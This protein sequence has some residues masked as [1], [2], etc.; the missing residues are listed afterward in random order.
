MAL[1]DVQY[2][3]RAQSPGKDPVAKLYAIESH[4]TVDD[5]TL[6]SS[7]FVANGVFKQYKYIAPNIASDSQFSFE[8]QDQDDAVIFSSGNI[9]D[10]KST[11]VVVKITDDNARLLCSGKN[12]HYKTVITWDTSGEVLLNTFKILLSLV[13]H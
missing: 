8:I 3:D 9:A 6:T 7:N 1:S 2:D 4:A 11:P 13:N 5:T 12:G 10:D